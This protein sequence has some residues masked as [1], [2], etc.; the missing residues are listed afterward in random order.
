MAPASKIDDDIARIEHAIEE[1][2][3][4]LLGNMNGTPG[5]ISRVRQLEQQATQR[6]TP[7][8]PAIAAVAPASDAAVAL[9]WLWSQREAALKLVTLVLAILG[10]IGHMQGCNKA[11]VAISS[12]AAPPTADGGTK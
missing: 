9:R 12:A 10:A 8:P 5:L 2:R 4:A 3:E 6:K 7:P 11:A 1:I